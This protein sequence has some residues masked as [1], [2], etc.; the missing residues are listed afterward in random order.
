MRGL[1]MILCAIACSMPPDP[2]EVIP[3]EPFDG[4]TPHEHGEHAAPEPPRAPLDPA[5]TCGRAEACCAAFAEVTPHVALDTACA[6]PHAAASLP[7]ADARCAR[8]IRGWRTALEQHEGLAMPEA[9]A[10]R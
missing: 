7:D 4:P 9:C 6:E 3:A 5:T 10:S 1:W 2:P 8:M